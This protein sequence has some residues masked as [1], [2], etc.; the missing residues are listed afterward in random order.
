MHYTISDSEFTFISQLIYRINSQETYETVCSTVMNQLNLLIPFRKGIIFQ[1]IEEKPG[2]VYRHPITCSNADI[3]FDETVFMTGGYRSDWLKNASYPWSNVF[4]SSDIRDEEAFQKSRLHRDV[5]APQDIYYG[6]HALLVHNDQKLAL[7]GLFR[8]RDEGDFTDK[9]V[10]IL[11]GIS[12]HLE[13]KLYQLYLASQ[14]SSRR[15]LDS[16]MD[17]RMMITQQK[18]LT[19]RE[20]DVVYLIH[21]GKNNQEIASELFISKATLEKHLYNIYRKFDVNSRVDLIYALQNME[22]Y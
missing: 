1:I 14:S 4:R 9:E 3:D 18:G 11:D 10:F 2:L 15:K 16:A 7:V 8:S 19:K 13:W 21:T 20:A 12:I 22:D 17:Y 5:Y 6:L